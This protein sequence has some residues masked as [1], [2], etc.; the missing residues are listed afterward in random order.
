ME[1][2]IKEMQ[3]Q[4]A[5]LKID[6]NS[7][8]ELLLSKLNERSVPCIENS[9]RNNIDNS[10]SAGVKNLTFMLKLEFPKFDNTGLNEWIR[11]VSKYFELCKVFEDQKV[12]LASLYMVDKATVWVVG[13]LAMKTMIGWVKFSMAVRARFFDEP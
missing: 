13:F 6:M 12:D 2:Q 11:K 7:K 9:S 5:E 3:S 8:F 4:I 1:E 10:R